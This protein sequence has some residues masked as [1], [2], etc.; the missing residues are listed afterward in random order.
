MAGIQGMGTPQGIQNPVAADVPQPPPVPPAMP[1]QATPA[2]PQ[3]LPG[4]ELPA[5]QAQ[6]APAQDPFDEIYNQHMPA[7]AATQPTADPFDAIYSQ[8]VKGSFAQAQAEAS[9]QPDPRTGD[10]GNFIHA[11]GRDRNATQELAA[12]LAQQWHQGGARLEFGFADSDKQ[13]QKVLEKFYGTDNVM[14]KGEQWLVKQNG[15]KWQNFKGKGLELIGDAA[16]SVSTGIEQGIQQAATGFGLAAAGVETATGAGVAVAPF[17]VAGM[18]AAGG[19]AGHGARQFIKH[20]VFNIPEDEHKSQ[21]QGYIAAGLLAPIAL[22]MSDKF[23]QAAAARLAANELTPIKAPIEGFKSEVENITTA[24][25]N[26]QEAGFLE[27][28]PGTDTPLALHQLNPSNPVAKAIAVEANK[29]PQLNQAMVEQQENFGKTANKFLASIANMGETS[30][31]AEDFTTHVKDIRKIEGKFIDD[32]RSAAHEE[33]GNSR[34]GVPK[35]I[36]NVD[37]MAQDLGY[38]HQGDKISPPGIQDLVDQGYSE[39][40][41]KLLTSKMNRVQKVLQEAVANDNGKISLDQLAGLYNDLNTTYGNLIDKGI[42]GDSLLNGKVGQLRA[43]IRDEYTDKLVAYHPEGNIRDLYQAK[44]NKFRSIA[45]AT[46]QLKNVLKDETSAYNMTK[47]IFADGAERE[48]AAV[49]TMLQDKPEM[50]QNLVAQHLRDIK[51][52]N[53]NPVTDSTN[54]GKFTTQV[55]GKNTTKLEDMFGADAAKQ[56]K[57]FTTVAKAIEEGNVGS[58]T[59]AQKVSFLKDLALSP[60]SHYAKANILVKLLGEAD[61]TGAL[62]QV[63]TKD[64]I[65]NFLKYAPPNKRGLLTTMLT[66]LIQGNNT[67]TN[68]TGADPAKQLMNLGRGYV[69]RNFGN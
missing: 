9:A 63:L 2:K 31:V 43:I 28:I 36:Q 62:K 37:A 67:I 50:W 24:A 6:A 58:Y 38:L 68:A 12:S 51:A 21:L 48:R 64:G 35:L 26:M 19:V 11:L 3:F 55:T 8:H 57:A 29:L 22:A 49:K 20:S 42:N 34:V 17:T 40:S 25:K 15:E 4:D 23:G 65:D 32:I 33:A 60:F 18:R 46:D 54:W 39:S 52:A 30:N 56:F 59:P 44:L 1:A 13:R 14:H 47:R 61:A 45:Q 27:N 5:E 53:Y 69:Q 16:D 7:S 41:A 66:P 10:F